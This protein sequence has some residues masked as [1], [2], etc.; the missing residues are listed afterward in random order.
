M[1]LGNDGLLV[2]ELRLEVLDLGLEDAELSC[3]AELLRQELGGVLGDGF[4][5]S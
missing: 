3:E 4:E 2:G 1:F 5:G